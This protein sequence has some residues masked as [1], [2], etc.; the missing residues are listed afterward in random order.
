L[1]KRGYARSHMSRQLITGT[2]HASVR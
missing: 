2:S 1:P